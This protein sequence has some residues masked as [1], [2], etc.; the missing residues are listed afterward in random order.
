M[1]IT[2][3][4]RLLISS[5]I[6]VVLSLSLTVPQAG[7]TIYINSV[8][9]LSPQGD[10]TSA[11]WLGYGTGAYVGFEEPATC[12]SLSRVNGYW[13]FVDLNFNGVTSTIT[14]SNSGSNV[15]IN[16]VDLNGWLNYT[17]DG[18]GIQVFSVLNEPTEVY[19]DGNKT[20][21][22][23]TY[24]NYKS[25]VTASSATLNVALSFAPASVSISFVADLVSFAS[26]ILGALTLIAVIIAISIAIIVMERKLLRWHK[27]WIAFAVV[28]LSFLSAAALTLTL[29]YY[30][31]LDVEY[32]T[33]TVSLT[34]S[35]ETVLSQPIEIETN[36]PGY[37]E[38]AG[39]AYAYF[40]SPYASAFNNF[41]VWMSLPDASW[42]EVP[43]FPAQ[44]DNRGIMTDLGRVNLDN[45][46]ITINM[47]YYFPQQ[48]I[49]FGTKT[50][51]ENSFIGNVQIVKE[52]TPRDIIQWIM[53]FFT[54]FAF[55]FGIPAFVLWE[56]LKKEDVKN[57][58]N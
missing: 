48:T 47:K 30:E 27:L 22:G 14:W 39:R 5:L 44:T 18:R 20:L 34:M 23:W 52:T 25:M 55:I 31:S 54:M 15:T 28:W 32:Y 43:L 10:Y 38:S 26:S 35:N 42:K 17:V 58:E 49:G 2:K 3:C 4:N 56:I 57:I 53:V 9:G 7:A 16:N 33:P 13:T 8:Y 24:S 45:V 6:L 41:T 21:T 19:I 12:S 1:L 29:Q 50:D 40:S 37:F 51:V 11:L 36:A 46:Q